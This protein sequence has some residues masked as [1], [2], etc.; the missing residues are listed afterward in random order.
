MKTQPVDWLR[1]Q[2]TDAMFHEPW[3]PQIAEPLRK[4]LT[5]LDLAEEKAA[6]ERPSN[7]PSVEDLKG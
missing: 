5:L 6:S 1:D 3:V 7:G 2:S 4:P